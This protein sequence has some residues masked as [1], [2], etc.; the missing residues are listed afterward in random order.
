[1]PRKDTQGKAFKLFPHQNIDTCVCRKCMRVCHTESSSKQG[2]FLHLC[3]CPTAGSG[4]APGSTRCDL[5]CSRLGCT[6]WSG[7]GPRFG[8]SRQTP[9]L[10]CA[11]HSGSSSSKREKE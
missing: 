9:L 10:G 3:T 2:E 4:C 1:M 11:L 7:G 6:A 5:R 8:A